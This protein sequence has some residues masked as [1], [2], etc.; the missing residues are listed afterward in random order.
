MAQKEKS[1]KSK[2]KKDLV[3]FF[4]KNKM[5][6]IFT[7]ALI[8]IVLIIL[9]MQLF[10][11][12]NFIIGN[13]LAVKL[14]VNKRDLFLLHGQEDK[15]TF[16]TE[17][18]ANPF[19]KIKCESSFFDISENKT[20]K[21]V[22]FNTR[23]EIIKKMEYTIN[24]TKMGSGQK[25]YRFS[26]S[27]RNIGSFFCHTT[28]EETIRRLIVTV[29]YDL[30]GGD[31]KMQQALK[32]K[33]EPYAKDI[34]NINANL[35]YLK[36]EISKLNQTLI[37]DDSET[38][39]DNAKKQSVELQKELDS[40]EDLWKRQEYYIL[41]DTVFIL[42]N[43]LQTM[44]QDYDKLKEI[45]YSHISIYN[46]LI[47]NLSIVKQRL[48]ALKDLQFNETRFLE[49]NSIIK[50][51]NQNI[52]L[53]ES[54]K[55]IGEKQNI[56]KALLGIDISRFYNEIYENETLYQVNETLTFNLAKIELAERNATFN[57]SL[58]EPMPEC[59]VFSKCNVCESESE[60][61]PILFLHG[62]DFNKDIS[63]D[64]SLNSFAKLQKKL[65]DNGYLNAGEMSLYTPLRNSSGFL[66]LS[67]M[68]ISIRASYYFD[69]FKRPKDYMA[70][71]TKSENIDTYSIRL[72]EVIDNLKYETN[73]S[74]V[75][76]IAH[77]MGG[78]VARRYV[79]IFGGESIEKLIL[80]NAPNKGIVGKVKGY[81]SIFGAELECRDMDSES[82]FMNKLNKDKTEKVPTYNIHGTGC[83][84]D[85]GMGDGIVL[86]QNGLLEEAV[87]Y[88]IGGNCSGTN[89]LHGEMLDINKYPALYETV[90]KILK[91]KQF[92]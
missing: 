31:K 14:D 29:E 60:K 25:L 85:E 23:P 6:T 62:H 32:A 59:C 87:N 88:I 83:Q 1:G 49:A 16:E 86:E 80:V 27:C 38:K 89:L 81:C 58:A 56:A 9:G 22:S 92:L 12:I 15:I 44:Q 19:C 33:I 7:F 46:S 48:E 36:S 64:Y 42:K 21:A 79:Q 76:I 90:K 41:G 52:S 78:L 34:A 82:L 67:S 26:I 5:V 20:I 66:G 73:Q 51:F 28:E 84:M 18:T 72:R 70:V 71:Q 50:D 43:S 69:V 91:T 47:E 8:A 13:D 53:F 2:L 68:P 45:V 75:I 74:K 10:L 57:F 61:Y 54:K 63:A 65:E 40:A 77:S 4:K 3:G 37:I 24:V 17:S 30:N 35:D 39:I 11:Y 55:D